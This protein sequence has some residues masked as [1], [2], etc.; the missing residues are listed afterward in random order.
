[1]EFMPFADI[2]DN[3]FLRVF[4]KNGD[5]VHD[6]DCDCDY[7]YRNGRWWLIARPRPVTAPDDDFYDIARH[8]YDYL[9]A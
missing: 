3:A 4:P 9:G 2:D 8:D 5:I 6:E 7:R 1:M